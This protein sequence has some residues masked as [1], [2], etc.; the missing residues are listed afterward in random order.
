MAIQVA[1]SSSKPPKAKK[2][3]SHLELHPRLGGGHIVRHVYQGYQHEPKDVQF[4]EDG[5]SQGGEHITAH[6]KKHA[7]LPGLDHDGDE[8]ETEGEAE[9]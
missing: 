1:E 6:L 2:V 8:P 3:L 9:E 5:K 4:N 7:G